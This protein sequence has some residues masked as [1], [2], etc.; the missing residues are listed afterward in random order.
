MELLHQIAIGVGLLSFFTFV[1][2]FGRLPGL[3][4][5][6]IGFLQVFLVD[7]LPRV[8]NDVDH[9]ITGGRF[10]RVLLQ[11]RDYLFFKRNPI[12]MVIFLFI[13]SGASFMF[14]RATYHLL[15]VTQ[16]LPIPVLLFLPYLF[17]YL[18]ASDTSH[19]I[20]TSNHTQSLTEYP[21]DFV[22]YHPAQ[23]CKT[24]HTPKPARSKHCSLCNRCVSRCDHHCPWVNACLGRTNYRYF[25]LLLLSLPI[26]EMYGAYLGY[27]I[28]SPHLNFAPLQGKPFFSLLYWNTLA[29]I[30]MIATDRGGL[31]IAGVSIL[32][33]TT[34][35]LPFA[36][37][38]YHIYLIWAGTTTN[39]NAKWGYLQEDMDDGFVWRG[40]RSEVLALR[41]A[42]K[43]P[44]TD[45]LEE[46]CKDW[47]IDS[48]QIVVRT[49]DGLA[50]R[51]ME[52]V[53]EQI[54]SLRGVDNIYDLG[55]WDNLSYILR[56][57]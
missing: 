47:P 11:M 56:G 1:V 43:G 38:S 6:P 36:L 48:D 27:T 25:L 33:A 18:C 51:G 39:E 35:P 13:L 10:V 34:A 17:T 30:C 40:K 31:S 14:L 20:T 46:Q 41:R 37:L 42:L 7:Y 9:K 26:L 28:L 44:S 29:R 24:C 55:F 3:R 12:V 4:K 5:T 2:L 21:Y 49:R 22:L 45:P 15:T 57:R 8:F 53:Y 50:P 19:F 52:D 32:A 23:E 54:W 16:I